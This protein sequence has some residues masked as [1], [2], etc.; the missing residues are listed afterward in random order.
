M[1][2]VAMS[3]PGTFVAQ[4]GDLPLM[5]R[6]SLSVELTDPP[7]GYVLNTKNLS[8]GFSLSPFSVLG[9]ALAFGVLAIITLERNLQLIEE[10]KA[11]YVMGV[12]V[13]LTLVKEE[14]R[15]RERFDETR[16]KIGRL[17]TK[18][19]GE[20]DPQEI[21]YRGDSRSTRG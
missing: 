12:D 13:S 19:T 2:W 17:E 4:I 16:E 10:R 1:Q 6:Y 3:V 14:R 11:E 9:K 21:G 18:R 15:L 20:A 8:S 7:L 5:G